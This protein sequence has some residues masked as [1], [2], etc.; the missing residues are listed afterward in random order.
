MKFDYRGYSK[1]HHNGDDTYLV[2]K[3]QNSNQNSDENSSWCCVHIE[4][5]KSVLNY[6]LSLRYDIKSSIVYVVGVLW[7]PILFNFYLCMKQH[8]RNIW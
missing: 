7:S 1:Y 6:I 2:R 3:Q 4:S 5:Y 8:R